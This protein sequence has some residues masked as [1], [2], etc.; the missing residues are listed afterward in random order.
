MDDLISRQVAL[1]PYEDLRDDDLICVR[2]I[3]EN[4]KLAQIV[5]RWILVTERVPEYRG[6]YLVT[7]LAENGYHRSRE[8]IYFG[9]DCQWATTRNVTAWMP[10]PEMWNGIE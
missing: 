5:N 2:T 3:R 7:I 1:A 10:L 6:Y 8:V 4:L 9:D